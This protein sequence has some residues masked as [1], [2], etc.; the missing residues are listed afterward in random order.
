MT[1]KIYKA[2][3]LFLDENSIVPRL[4]R[5]YEGDI[6]CWDSE[7]KRIYNLSENFYIPSDMSKRIN[8]KDPNNFE[9]LI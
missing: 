2:K 8:L 7:L 5:I 1:K 4:H 6:V 3:K 9:L